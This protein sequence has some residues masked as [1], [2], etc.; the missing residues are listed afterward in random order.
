MKRWQRWGTT[1]AMA[2][3]TLLGSLVVMGSQVLALTEQQVKEKL[4]PVPVFTVTDENGSPLVA[5]LPAQGN[6]DERAAVAGVFMSWKAAEAFVEQLKKR[7]PNLGNKIQVVPV[8]LAEVYALKQHNRNKPDALNFSYVPAQQQVQHAQSIWTQQRKSL[9]Q[10][11]QNNV[12]EKFQGTPLFVAK[13]GPQGGYL[14]IQQDGEQIIPFFFEKEQLQTLVDRFKQQN[15]NQA[16]SVQ[17]Q[18]LPLEGVI[19]TLATQNSPELERILLVPSRESLE[20]LDSL[21]K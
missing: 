13:A 14:T 2:G 21:K 19:R 16:S 5:N 10:Q 20:F 7:E 12:P 18:V 15:P 9:P 8:S 3:S 11:R 17:I 1:L 4:Q 6:P